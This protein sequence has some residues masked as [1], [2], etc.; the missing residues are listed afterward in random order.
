M[1]VIGAIAAGFRRVMRARRM[2]VS[3]WFVS[4]LVALPAAWARTSSDST[5]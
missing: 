1:N 3:L 2:A 4:F 5:R